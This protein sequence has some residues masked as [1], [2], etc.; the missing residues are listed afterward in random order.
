VRDADE[1]VGYVKRTV[2]IRLNG[3]EDK[4]VNCELWQNMCFQYH[5]VDAPDNA[6]YSRRRADIFNLL[7]LNDFYVLLF[8]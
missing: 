1:R 2:S 5:G 4:L 6:N 3:G 8:A 7:A